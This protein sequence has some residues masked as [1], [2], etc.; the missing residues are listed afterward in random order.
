MH[1]QTKKLISFGYIF[2]VFLINFLISWF[3][4]SW[5]SLDIAFT[6]P[7]QS[8]LGDIFWLTPF[9][10]LLVQ[11]WLLWKKRSS[12]KFLLLM[13]IGAIL[14]YALLLLVVDRISNFYPQEGFTF[15]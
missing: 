14:F 10:F 1:S 9:C 11:L 5:I 6:Y 7:S 8:V 3:A 13:T 2:I 15:L 4:L 12:W